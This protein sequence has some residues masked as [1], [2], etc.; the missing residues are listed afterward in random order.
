M[1]VCDYCLHICDRDHFGLVNVV[2][3][4]N[5]WTTHFIRCVTMRFSYL[6][7]ANLRRNLRQLMVSTVP[8]D[9]AQLDPAQLDPAQLGP[10]HMHCLL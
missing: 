8:L 5:Y 1:C 2:I 7:N 4:G 9:P 3:T 6:L 10:A